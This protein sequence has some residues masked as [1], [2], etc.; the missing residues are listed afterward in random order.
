MRLSD[1]DSIRIHGSAGFPASTLFTGFPQ[2]EDV[3]VRTSLSRW[4]QA[5]QYKVVR[6]HDVTVRQ[7]TENITTLT[8]WLLPRCM[9]RDFCGKMRELQCAPG[10]CATQMPS[11]HKQVIVRKM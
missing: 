8:I 3:G 6:Q 1:R 10:A 2:G 4:V 7:A 11:T 5:A 9:L